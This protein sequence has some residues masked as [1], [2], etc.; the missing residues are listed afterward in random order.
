MATE[1]DRVSWSSS[2]ALDL[3]LGGASFI[4][5]TGRRIF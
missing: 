2:A 3:Y 1:L 5:V 4:S